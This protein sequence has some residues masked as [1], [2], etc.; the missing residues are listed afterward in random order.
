M[1]STTLQIAAGILEVAGL[2]IFCAVLHEL[3]VPDSESANLG[4]L[5]IWNFAGALLTLIIILLGECRSQVP[6]D[7][8]QFSD[9]SLYM[10]SEY[11]MQCKKSNNTACALLPGALLLFFTSAQLLTI[12]HVPCKS[13]EFP[14]VVTFSVIFVGLVLVFNHRL[15]GD[16]HSLGHVLGVAGVAVCM[17]FEFVM[18][19]FHMYGRSEDGDSGPKKEVIFRARNCSELRVDH[20]ALL[21]LVVFNILTVVLF[22][23]AWVDNNPAAVALE[24]AWVVLLWMLFLFHSQHEAVS[25]STRPAHPHLFVG[26]LT[27]A[28]ALFLTFQVLLPD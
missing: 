20:W 3:R 5:Q 10:I 17:P 6:L 16:A 25:T 22:L 7:G 19:A 26:L 14:T 1:P 15:D 18:I 8:L 27:S 11:I 24:Y 13:V 2:A 28:I 9:D 4:T 12:R 21:T 23:S